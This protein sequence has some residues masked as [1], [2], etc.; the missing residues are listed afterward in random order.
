MADDFIRT[1][2]SDAE[3]ASDDDIPQLK[4]KVAGKARPD[5]GTALN[6]EFV[7]DLTGDTYQDIL[8]EHAGLE[9]IVKSGSKPVSTLFAHIP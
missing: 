8:K 5:K 9:D 7:F 4:Q 2:D 3:I 1:I 6:P